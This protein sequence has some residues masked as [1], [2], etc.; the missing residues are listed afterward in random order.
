MTQTQKTSIGRAIKLTWKLL[1]KREKKMFFAV[2]AL[3]ILAGL[4]STLMIGSIMPFL[5]LLSNPETLQTN[6]YLVAFREL[7]GNPEPNT[8]LIVIGM[9]SLLVIII[10]NVINGFKT[11]AVARYV[12]MR[13]YSFSKQMFELCLRQPYE[14]FMTTPPAIFS[15]R[16]IGEPGEVAQKFLMPLAELISGIITFTI[17]VTFLILVSPLATLVV[18]TTLSMVF[19]MIALLT[20][21]KLPRLGE[22]RI[23][24]TTAR[25]HIFQEIVR[26]FREIR[27]TGQED[28]FVTKFSTSSRELSVIQT[29][30]NFLSQSSKFWVQ[31]FFYSGIISF[32]LYFVLK[33]T[34]ETAGFMEYIPT[35]G[36]FVL[37]GQRLLPEIQLIYSA[38]TRLLYGAPSVELLWKARTDMLK[39]QNQEDE[40]TVEAIPFQKEIQ[41]KNLQYI[42]PD[43]QTGLSQ[44]I[45]LIIPKNQKIGIVGES[46]SGKSTLISILMGLLKPTEGAITIDG[47]E[48]VS[49]NM[50]SWRSII[51]QVPQDV[52]LLDTTLERNIA[53]G[54]EPK[55][56]D[57]NKIYKILKECQLEN[58]YATLPYGLDTEIMKGT[59]SLSGG[60]R[61]RIGLA[62]A[63]Y[64]ESELLIFDEATSALDAKTEQEIMKTLNTTLKDKTAVVVAHR[65]STLQ[66]CDRIVSLGKD[67]IEFDGTW[68]EFQERQNTV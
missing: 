35:I 13:S 54:V 16:A 39:T 43:G 58:W 67:G 36:V 60:Q 41:L 65:L 66:N 44:P 46:G 25:G 63:L 34:G 7:I 22:E 28:E 4:M 37:A 20:R 27:M 23:A 52:M 55:D 30:T 3:T 24:A 18:V 6:K 14:T 31:G 49:K 2:L 64:R 59:A 42:Y 26:C 62:R 48:I 53:L 47:Q 32:C 12:N 57:R 9:T 68:D 50:K 1:Q 56:I 21:G 17:L 11:Y 45:N 5:L 15:R 10:A 38:R 29:Q 61:Q 8:T 33:D 51:S 40:A 19:G